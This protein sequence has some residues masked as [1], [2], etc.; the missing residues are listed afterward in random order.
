MFKTIEIKKGFNGQ[1]SSLT[2]HQMHSMHI[3]IHNVDI[4]L[5][6]VYK[7]IWSISN[8]IN[9]NNYYWFAFT[10]TLIWFTNLT[11]PCWLYSV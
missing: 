6:F 10:F 11:F 1:L 8:H 5:T 2:T 9:L 4:L 3:I 7:H